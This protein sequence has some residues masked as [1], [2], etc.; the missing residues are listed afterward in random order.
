MEN[1]SNFSKPTDPE[2][3]KIK[4]KKICGWCKKDMGEIEGS[5]EKIEHGICSDCEE[6]QK[7]KMEEFKKRLKESGGD[8]SKIEED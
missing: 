3:E 7:K 1:E 8:V 4:R 6:I 5:D 2:V